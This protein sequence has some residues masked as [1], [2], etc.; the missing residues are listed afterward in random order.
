M[1]PLILLLLIFL[2]PKIGFA[3]PYTADIYY[4][5]GDGP[6]PVIIL[7]HG[8]GGPSVVYKKKAEGMARN[9]RAAVV[10]DHYSARGDYGAKFR[11]I[12][13]LSDA[14]EW[15][16]KDILDLLRTLKSDNKIK[17]DKVILAGWSAGSGI[18]LPFVSNPRRLTQPEGITI[19]GAMLTYPYTAGC[20]EEINSFN[21]PVIIHFGKLDG[22]DGNPL[23][24]YHCWKEKVENFNDRK[25]PVIFKEYA[26]AYHGYDLPFLKNRPKRCQKRKYKD[27]VGEICMAFNQSAF[28][29]AIRANGGFL[30]K[31][32]ND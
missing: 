21:V 23:T 15:R 9:G 5:E 1:K 25:V 22:N 6:F 18:V 11:N 19:V 4:P 7:S 2:A 17:K 26:D 16:E 32:L 27:G 24:G 13:K 20:Q 29:Q 31:L 10:L 12:P 28:K 14:R 30:R 3:K 8:A